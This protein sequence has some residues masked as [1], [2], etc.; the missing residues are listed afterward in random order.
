MS[1]LSEV[2]I[3]LV[4]PNDENDASH[5]MEDFPTDF[6][7]A[8]TKSFPRAELD[9]PDQ[10]M[11]WDSFVVTSASDCSSP[12]EHMA[13]M[14]IGNQVSDICNYLVDIFGDP[15]KYAKFLCYRDSAAQDLLDLL[16]KVRE[17]GLI[18]G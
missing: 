3:V 9:S 2:K 18:F 7:L 15:H 17:K 10:S 11:V 16:Q 1:P 13:S 6:L 12:V 14:E 8:R 4:E 5:D